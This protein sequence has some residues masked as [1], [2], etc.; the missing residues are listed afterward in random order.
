MAV[1]LSA[2]GLEQLTEAQAVIDEH[3]V[4]CATCGT[5]R[6]CAERREAEAVFLRYGRLPRRK[7]GRTIRVEVRANNGRLRWLGNAKEHP[8]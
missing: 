5:N 2:A 6:P 7:P 3:T 4:S 1:Y 8:L